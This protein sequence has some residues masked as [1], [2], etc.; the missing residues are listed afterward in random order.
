MGWSVVLLPVL[1]APLVWAVGRRASARRRASGAL[2]LGT[3]V[4][5]CGLAVLAAVWRPSSTYRWSD[6][7]SLSLAVDDTA[8]VVVVLVPAVALVVVAYAAVHEAE[9]GLPRLLG[10]LVAFVGAMELLVLAADL[11]TLLVAWELVA[12]CSWALIG[13]R[14]WEDGAGRG[15]NEAFVVTRVGDLG[16]F[17]AVGAAF[18]GAGSASYAE[19]PSLS[20]GWLTVVAV[21]VVL[22]AAAKSAQ[23]PFSPWLFSAMVGPTSVSALLHAATMVAA[24]GYLLLRLQP[25]LSTLDWFGPVVLALGLV[26]AVLGGVVALL[27]TQPKRLLAASTSAQFGLVFVAV[28]A[29]F[30]A[31]GLVH[32][33][34]HAALKAP[35]FLAGGMVMEA[36]GEEDLRRMRL[37]RALP[38]V[39]VATGVCAAALAA[40]PPLG[41]AWSKEEVVTSAGHVA[42]WLVVAV[43]VAGGLS[44]AYATRFALE[45]FGL[46]PDPPDAALSRDAHAVETGAVVVGAAASIALG[47]LWLPGATDV[48]EDLTGGVVPTGEP[49]EL[50]LSLGFVALGAYAVLV[51]DRRRGPAPGSVERG[52]RLVRR[53]GPPADWLGLPTLGRRVVAD[54]VLATGAALAEVDRVV[55]D[56]PPRAVAGLG[57]TLSRDAA[58]GD[59]V[60]VDAGVRGVARV[61]RWTANVAGRV[62][63]LGVDGAVRGV[64]TLVA[65]AGRD[66]RHHHG[67]LVPRYYVLVV[68]GAGLLIGAATLWS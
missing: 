20:S 14:W 25:A 48:V 29:G 13:H 68:G 3:L 33:V 27:Q 43:S 4:A 64:A 12:A 30:P 5:T 53:D 23:V 61:T 45:G 65:R 66:L 32:L 15:A 38:V 36:A 58:R 21:G 35:L 47:A 10:G 1:A 62:S 9:R 37:G 28:G 2:A 42:S 51:A 22:A 55:L 52:G 50:A 16:L 19:L 11:L 31:V 49:W 54:P 40:V 60:V 56:A 8:A 39:A 44:A 24:G 7:L 63:E 17:A 26:T 67:R 57:R 46:R 34:A 41:A 6:L 59:G 18:A